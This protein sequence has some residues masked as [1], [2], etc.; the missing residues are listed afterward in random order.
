MFFSGVRKRV[1]ARSVI[2][3]ITTVTIIKLL[4]KLNISYICFIVNAVFKN[5]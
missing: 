4:W 2:I 1:V 5:G 3:F